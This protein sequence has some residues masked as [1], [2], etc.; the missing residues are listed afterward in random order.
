MGGG[1]VGHVVSLQELLSLDA[2]VTKASR[3]AFPKKVRGTASPLFHGVGSANHRK[4]TAKASWSLSGTV[5]AGRTKRS[6]SKFHDVGVTVTPPPLR[7]T[8]LSMRPGSGQDSASQ[9]SA[10]PP[11]ERS[12]WNWLESGSV[13]VWRLKSPPIITALP[14]EKVE[15]MLSIW[16]MPS[17]GAGRPGDRR[18][19]P[20]GGCTRPRSRPPRAWSWPR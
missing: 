9:T 12:R 13:S 15:S 3:S 11:K 19:P 14:A 1:Q 5:L 2:G 10:R 17:S 7:K 18:R 20:C 6:V 16:V 8:N 4:F